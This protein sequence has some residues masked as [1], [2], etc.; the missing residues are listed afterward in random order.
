M[1]GKPNVS[2]SKCGTLHLTMDI[3]FNSVDCPKCKK[4]YMDDDD[5]HTTYYNKKTC[6]ITG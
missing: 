2:V 6:S 1:K 4:K 3:Y 5:S